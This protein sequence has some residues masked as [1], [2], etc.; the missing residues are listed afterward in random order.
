VRGR[1][2]NTYLGY[3]K[4]N[5]P[6]GIIASLVAFA[7]WKYPHY[8]NSM[9]TGEFKW[10]TTPLTATSRVF[11]VR[12]VSQLVARVSRR[13]CPSMSTSE[14]NGIELGYLGCPGLSKQRQPPVSV[15]KSSKNNSS[16]GGSV[17]LFPTGP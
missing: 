1:T 13:C 14:I 4:T 2:G 7:T 6:G 16:D 3:T 8:I 12:A 10:L 9:S 11:S 15:S 5:N 17:P